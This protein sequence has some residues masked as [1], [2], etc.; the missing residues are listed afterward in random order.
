MKI[1]NDNKGDID[2]TVVLTAEDARDLLL[3]LR[4]D[5]LAMGR[6]RCERL[7]DQLTGIL[8]ALSQSGESDPLFC[9]E[10]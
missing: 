10:T 5:E 3:A 8:V 7:S 2:G 1:L 4:T 6:H 9:Q